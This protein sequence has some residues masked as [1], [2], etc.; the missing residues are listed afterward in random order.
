MVENIPDGTSSLKKHGITQQPE[1]CFL[2]VVP[3][4]ETA[5]CSSVQTLSTYDT[6]SPTTLRKEHSDTIAIVKSQ[7]PEKQNSKFEVSCLGID[8]NVCAPEHSCLVNDI[9]VKYLV[10]FGCKVS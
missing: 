10:K 7:L 3:T 6:K 1:H 9:E 4:K 8:V 5:S 2:N